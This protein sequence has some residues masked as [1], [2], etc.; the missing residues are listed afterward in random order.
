MAITVSIAGTNRSSLV[1]GRSLRIDWKLGARAVCRMRATDKN[2]SYRPSIGNSVLVSDGGTDIYLGSIEEFSEGNDNG[3]RLF[4]IAATGIERRLD[5]LR[6]NAVAFGRAPFTSNSIS[7]ILTFDVQP[8]SNGYPVQVRTTGSAPGGLNTSTTYYVRDATSTTCK[9]AAT[10]G[11]SAINL[12]SDGSGNHH[13]VWCAGAIVQNL[14][15]VYGTGEGLS[16][17]TINDGTAIELATFEYSTISDMI[18]QVA[19]ASGYIWRGNADETVDFIP[20]N[21]D[22]APF[23]ANTTTVIYGTVNVRYTREEYANAVYVRYNEQ[24]VAPTLVNFTGD[25]SKRIFRCATVIKSVVTITVDAAEKTVGV[26]GVD[27]GKDWYYT[28]GDHFV[29]QDSGGTVLTG[30]N[31]LYVTYRAFGFDSEYAEDTTEQTNRAS[32]EGGTGVYEALV[33]RD[34]IY[35]ADA[36]EDAA[37]A[38]LTA[39][40]TLPVELRYQTD[41]AG[42]LPGQLQTV[43]LSSW[44]ISSGT[45]LIDEV[46]AEDIDVGYLRYTVRALSTTR[47][48][49]YLSVFKSF[50]G[51]GSSSVAGTSAGG[52]GGS[53]TQQVFLYSVTFTA[54]TAV[55]YAI[56]AAGS[57]LAMVITQDGTGGWTVSSWGSEFQDAPDIVTAA[58]ARNKLLWYSDGTKWHLL[59]VLQV[60]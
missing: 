25:G 6:V 20:R 45:Y 41:S 35:S 11:G 39:R 59:N 32:V 19:A 34:D 29:Y 48:G 7:D 30:S 43:N 12:T 21:G 49:D 13:L 3:V 23:D 8:F 10:A 4:E 36:A 26:Y 51:S 46:S 31:T 24:A 17:G 50:V 40:K 56:Q 47:L 16:A 28:P 52:G 57:L 14:L 54:N 18:E 1:S 60:S 55:T 9:L 22:A 44:G 42:L 15:T 38:E 37:T 5:R 58:G 53:S 2:A 27:S 33:Q